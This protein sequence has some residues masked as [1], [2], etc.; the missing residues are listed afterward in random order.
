MKIQA[1]A[2]RSVRNDTDLARVPSG[3]VVIVICPRRRMV[4]MVGVARMPRHFRDTL[5]GESVGLLVP[6][7]QPLPTQK[8]L[9]Q[10]KKEGKSR[11]VAAATHQ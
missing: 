7:P 2:R 11:D 9:S 1:T 3:N 4:R 8:E 6:V 10:H 5:G